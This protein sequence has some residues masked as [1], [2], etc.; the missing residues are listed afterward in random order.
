MGTSR[1]TVVLC[2]GGEPDA[3]LDW[4]PAAAG[5]EKWGTLVIRE[6]DALKI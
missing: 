1:N 3:S 6:A 2:G 4:I 5:N